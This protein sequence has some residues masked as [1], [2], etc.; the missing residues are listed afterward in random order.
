MAVVFNVYFAGVVAKDAPINGVT[1]WSFLIAGSALISGILSPYLGALADIQKTRKRWLAGCALVG[2]CSTT[3]LIVASPET[4]ALT[5]VLFVLASACFTL[6]LTF[7]HS[8]LND[9]STGKNIGQVSGFGWAIGYIGG[10]FCLA[11][12]LLMIRHPDWFHLPAYN[13]WPVRATFFVVGIWWLVFTVPI[14]LWVK[15]SHA[16]SDAGTAPI[17]PSP[18]AEAGRR[19]MDSF[20]AA[21]RYRKNLFLFLIAYLLFNDVIE[22]VIVMASIFAAM[23]LKMGPDEIVA[24]FL[25]IQFVA[26][27]GSLGFGKLADRWSNKKALQTSL[28]LWALMIGWTMG[29][30]TKTEFWIASI[31]V[32]LVLGGSQSVSRSLFGKLIPAGEVAQFYGFLGLSGKIS[33]AAGPL[34]FGLVHELTGRIRWAI[35]SMLILLILGQSLLALVKEPDSYDKTPSC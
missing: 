12:N 26:F 20:K 15:E 24:C 2:G 17:P 4:L 31:F 14:L 11:L 33:A 23:E 5:C 34:V 9:L 30:R 32:A 10:G 35:F 1:L 28:V 19:V 7:Y 25:M 16:A 6:S 22:T 29:M 3:A 8:F 18:L 27:F 21:T 13:Y